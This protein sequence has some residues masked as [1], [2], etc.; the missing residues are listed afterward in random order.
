ME[1]NLIDI[2]VNNNVIL[3]DKYISDL[4]KAYNDLYN[5]YLDY[6][7]INRV[8]FEDFSRAENI[9][10]TKNVLKTAVIRKQG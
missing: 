9:I 10:K 4:T 3:L 1:Q 8:Y 6:Q 2:I 5:F 7:A